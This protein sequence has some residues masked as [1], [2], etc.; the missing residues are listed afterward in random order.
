VENP[1]TFSSLKNL[2]DV[3]ILFVLPLIAVSWILQSGF[4]VSI[5]GSSYVLE[6]SSE[7]GI[8]MSLAVGFLILLFKTAFAWCAAIALFYVILIMDAFLK[9]AVFPVAA[10]L[11][12]TAGILSIA[13][14]VFGDIALEVHA[15]WGYSA[16]AAGL[17]IVN[18][19][20]QH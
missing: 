7:W 13:N 5:I 4:Q 10:M 18:L 9:G 20:K 8:A 14:S 2:E 16:L 17:F 3:S 12:L 1:I 11:L 19:N 15:I 6:V